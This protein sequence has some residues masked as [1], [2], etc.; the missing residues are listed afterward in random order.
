MKHRYGIISEIDYTSGTARVF[1]DDIGIVS[2]WLTLPQNTNSNKA[3]QL[4][5]QVAVIISENGEDGEILREIGDP[6]SW[7]SGSVEG[8]EFSDGTKVVY[9]NL[10]KKLTI[11]AG[12]GELEFKCSK[13]T[14]T[15]DVIAGVENISLVSHIHTSPSGPTGK[16]IPQP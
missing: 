6:P 15:G 4:K 1:F 3:Y 16:P 8:V 5:Q 7:A 2:D 9:D 13:L 14:V 12:G 11:D 10:S